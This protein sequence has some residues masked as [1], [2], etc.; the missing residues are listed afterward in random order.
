MVTMTRRRRVSGI[1]TL[2]SKTA[3]FDSAVTVLS[4]DC[5]APTREQL[6]GEKMY[7][8]VATVNQ[9]LR[10]ETIAS[11]GIQHYHSRL[12]R[13]LLSPPVLTR[14]RSGSFILKCRVCDDEKPEGCCV[15]CLTIYYCCPRCLMFDRA[16]HRNECVN[17]QVYERACALTETGEAALLR[18]PRY[19]FFEVT[20]EK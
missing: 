10:D 6:N 16:R 7:L 2:H 5:P 1:R 12:L 14:Q 8:S 11:G 3:S 15:F 9:R 20:G 4:T 18:S 13:S 17:L 19:D